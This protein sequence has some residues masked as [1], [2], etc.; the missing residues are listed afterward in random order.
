[1]QLLRSYADPS[2][3]TASGRFISA[4]SD[5]AGLAPVWEYFGGNTCPCG[6]LIWAS[7]TTYG[8]TIIS[9]YSQALAE[10]GKAGACVPYAP[11]TGT[12]GNGYYMLTTDQKVSAFGTAPYLGDVRGKHLNGPLIGGAT[13]SHADGYWL[14]G[15]DGGIFTFGKAKFYGSTGALRLKKPVNGIERTG[16]DGGYWLVADDGGIFTFGNAPFKGSTGAMH[17]NSP[18]VGMT[19][20]VSGQGYWLYAADGGIFTFGD[21]GFYG[22]LGSANL[23]SPVISMARTPSGHGYLMATRDGHVVSLRRRQDVRR[24]LVLRG[25][26]RRRG[27]VAALADRKRLLDRVEH[28]R[29]H[30]V[31]RRPPS[32]LPGLDQRLRRRSARRRLSSVCAQAAL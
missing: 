19:R 30:P 27:R 26:P 11:T 10:S 7:S 15:R 22:S 24:H 12:S 14:L 21:A 25:Q 1:M 16:N 8:V 28:R 13:T 5:R 9:L 6:K 18:I 20:T 29:G 31:R 3:K 2:A 23:K 4:P 32:R 17:L